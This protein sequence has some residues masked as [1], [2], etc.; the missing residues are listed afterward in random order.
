MK[1]RKKGTISKILKLKDSRKKELEF[2]R[3][4]LTGLIEL[5]HMINELP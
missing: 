1:S 3:H 5:K 2:D 4:F